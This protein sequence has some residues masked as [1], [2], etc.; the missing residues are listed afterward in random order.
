M[1]EGK[2]QRDPTTGKIKRNSTNGKLV[3]NS[4]SSATCCCGSSVECPLSC[5]DAP[6]SFYVTVSG[7]GACNTTGRELRCAIF[8]SC[9]TCVWTNGIAYTLECGEL[10]ECTGLPGNYWVLTV[11]SGPGVTFIQAYKVLLPGDTEPPTGTYTI[12]YCSAGSGCTC[13]SASVSIST[14]P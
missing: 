3:R 1:A 9:T 2:L 14:T 13:G 4:S 5:P 12:C 6:V 7:A 11:Q 8:G 10:F